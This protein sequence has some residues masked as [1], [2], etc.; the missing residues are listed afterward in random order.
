MLLER[1]PFNAIVL[2]V[3]MD[4]DRLGEASDRMGEFCEPET[5]Y[6]TTVE[7]GHKHD[8]VAIGAPRR[9]PKHENVPVRKRRSEYMV[10]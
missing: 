7:L 9:R 4:D 8:H 3:N 2:V 5:F 6:R 10:R 1:E